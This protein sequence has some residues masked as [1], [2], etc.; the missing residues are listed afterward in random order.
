MKFVTGAALVVAAVVLA[1]EVFYGFTHVYEDNARVQTDLTHISSQV[2]G[3]IDSILVAE[4]GRVKQGQLLIRL[5]DD[6]IRM[7]IEA[8]ATDL[9]LERAQRARLISEQTAFE[10]DL[11][12]RLAT[13]REKIRAVE[14][15][16]K[17]LEARLKLAEKNLGRVQFLFKKGL[18]PEEKL[19]LEQDKV[20]VLGGQERLLAARRQVAARELDQLA[21]SAKQI[22]VIEEKIKISDIEQARIE[23]AIAKQKISLG[24]RHITSPIDGTIGRIHKFKGEYVED[25]V[26]ILMLHDPN[27]FW[28]EAYIDESQIRHVRAGQEVLINL[29]AYPFED[30]FGHVRRIGSITTA[31]MGIDEIDQGSVGFGGRIERVPVRIAIDNP[32]PN[33]AP[34]MRA[35]INVRIYEN[36]KLW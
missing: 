26:N 27:L 31:Q 14:Q 35:N 12:S 8:L 34:G 23:D 13:Q 19:T 3:K 28:I 2:D 7:N 17:S 20:L 10:I 25:G 11:E 15:E 4:G 1:Y 18:K 36:I 22:D 30:F 5:V 9:Q 24:Y 16:H 21:A 29:E 33:L 32:P 6:D